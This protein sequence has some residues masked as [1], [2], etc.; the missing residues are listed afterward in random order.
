MLGCLAQ[1]CSGA[2]A[3]PGDFVVES[4]GHRLNEMHDRTPF[5]H[6]NA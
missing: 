1:R 2:Q 4:A 3:V 6:M 5:G